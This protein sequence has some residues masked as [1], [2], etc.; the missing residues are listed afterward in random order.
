MAAITVTA[1][2]TGTITNVATGGDKRVFTTT[3]VTWGA[4]DVGRFILITSGAGGAGS[5]KNQVYEIVA[6][7]T[8]QITVEWEH[9]A[10][11]YQS[12]WPY[13]AL[14]NGATFTVSQNCDDID[15]AS[16]LIK[17][18]AHEYRMNDTGGDTIT[19]SANAIWADRNI[20]L[21]VVSNRIFVQGA[22]VFGAMDRYG[23]CNQGCNIIDTCNTTNAWNPAAADTGTIL[24]FGSRY[25]MHGQSADTFL[26][27]YPESA[28]AATMANYPRGLF[29]CIISGRFGCRFGGPKAIMAENVFDN[30]SGGTGPFNPMALNA[31]G[32]T[33]N[34]KT[35]MF[36]DNKIISGAQAYYHFWPVSLSVDVA[37]LRY[38]PETITT[39]FA[40]TTKNSSPAYS[41]PQEVRFLDH[42]I[43]DLEKLT[44]TAQLNKPL[45]YYD[46]TIGVSGDKFSFWNKLNVTVVNTAA[47]AVSGARIRIKS[48]ANVEQFNGTTDAN[49]LP[50][51]T[52]L[53]FALFDDTG[54]PNLG[55]R[56]YQDMTFDGTYS[57]LLRKY[58]YLEQTWTFNARQTESMARF[59]ASD[60]SVVASEATALAYSGVS[61]NLATSVI[62]ISGTRTVQEMS[63]YFKAQS[64]QSANMQH[65]WPFTS[66]GAALAGP[67]SYVVQATGSV[68]SGKITVASGRS[69]TVDSGGTVGANLDL[70]SGSVTSLPTCSALSGAV[71]VAGT[72]S[73]ASLSTPTAAGTLAATGRFVLTGAAGGTL[74]NLQGCTITTGF[75][76]ENTSGS[77]MTVR[78]KLADAGKI[79][80]VPTSGTLTEDSS[81]T[82]N[83]SLPNLADGDRVQVYDTTNNAQKYNELVA[84]G[85]GWLKSETLI[86]SY[87]F[88]LRV[89]R[90]GKLPLN[91]VGTMTAS[92]FSS[93]ASLSND[94]IYAAN[95]I[96]GG[97]VSGVS[98]TD[99]SPTDFVD[100][101]RSSDTIAVQAIYAWLSDFAA[102]ATGIAARESYWT[103]QDGANYQTPD[104]LKLRNIKSS[105]SVATTITDGYLQGATPSQSFI[106]SNWLQT[107][108]G[109]AFQAGGD[110]VSQ[111]LAY[112]GEIWFDDVTGHAGTNFPI[113]TSADPVNNLPDLLAIAS[114]IGVRRIIIRSPS[115]VIT[116]PVEGF[117]VKSAGGLAVVVI[118]PV[119][120]VSVAGSSFR[121]CGITGQ[122]TGNAGY[123]DCRL[124]DVYGIE[125]SAARCGFTGDIRPGGNFSG[126]LCSAIGGGPTAPHLDLALLGAGE[127]A[128]LSIWSGEIVVENLTNATAV[129][130]IDANSASITVAPTCT[131][132]TV[133][134]RGSGDAI[135][136]LSAGALVIDS[137]WNAGGGGGGGGSATIDPQDVADAMLLTP[138]GLVRVGSV[139]DRLQD[140]ETAVAAL[141]APLQAAGYTAPNN[142]GIAAAAADAAAAKAAAQAVDAR[143][144]ASPATAA[145]VAAL[146]AP[147]QA[148]DYTAPDN[149]AATTAA[150]QA[151]AANANAQAATAAAA[152][153]EA[154]AELARAAAAAAA[155]SAAAIDARL[156][157]DPADQSTTST[158]IAGVPDAVWSYERP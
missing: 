34:G 42:R 122:M 155:A 66:W 132:G 26:R 115:M 7:A 49:G 107:V 15:N 134:L 106:A 139:Q 10:T 82:A 103:A 110:E 56:Y 80:Y 116:Q 8:N 117:E 2:R 55:S 120:P 119:T 51:T 149:A 22:V 86:A 72:V 114:N 12:E 52:W 44:S 92:G 54:T 150:A 69:L 64:C 109:R 28:Y 131:S 153:A 59:L 29:Q 142:A 58:E 104:D 87:N 30:A 112:N 111:A 130:A 118:G 81:V 57:Y 89:R 46:A 148:G 71:L 37:G 4:G 68:P 62:T 93:P 45:Y 27:L 1:T 14:A 65:A 77:P 31:G 84:G 21:R 136:D 143:L 33:S 102:T 147:L 108:Q 95:G 133:I 126:V 36:R 41:S 11:P 140:L 13:D 17:T 152:A 40:R 73:I 48:A 38:T 6:Q 19:V 128:G 129:C 144:P 90:K 125:G 135:T 47:A 25:Q 50:P 67:V 61:I 123:E 96:D 101:N 158:A 154:R 3:G 83:W 100:L 53:R 145:A 99:A 23:K 60:T 97:T 124:Q 43:D 9:D 137:G 5:P 157:S 39:R 127:A 24:F 18:S 85:A 76:V 78:V 94:D 32:G 63:D 98:F 105:P 91:I 88:R 138:I 20:S 75:T 113:G 16:A 156:P 141:G 79:T 151:S 70:L 74:L 35:G 146:G 121:E